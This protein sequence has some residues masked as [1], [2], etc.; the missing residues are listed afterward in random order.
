MKNSFFITFEGSEAVGKS[1][2]IQ[3]VADFLNDLSIDYVKT[4]EP[5]GTPL[6][7]K[8]R[9]LVFQESHRPSSITELLLLFAARK[10]H[11][12][13]LIR[14]SL[15]NNKIVLCD[16]YIDSTYV[17]QSMM[18]HIPQAMIDML[19]QNFVMPTIPDV[20]FIID[21]DAQ[22]SFNRI[23][24]R[25]IENRN[26]DKSVAYFEKLRQGFLERSQSN[27]GYP[28]VVI[29]NYDIDNAVKHITDYLLKVLI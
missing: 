24:S 20:C 4:R 8:I 19:V 25:G 15:D 26:D 11:I 3:K 28:Y 12:E 17:Y 16:R 21:C 10:D 13:Y 2:I 22:T 14:P 5:G 29:E 23:Q 27:N 9:G 18:N 1:T 6:A 7:E